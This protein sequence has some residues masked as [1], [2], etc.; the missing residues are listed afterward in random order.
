[1]RNYRVVLHNKYSGPCRSLTGR[2]DFIVDNNPT[3]FCCCLRHA[4]AMLDFYA[5][6]LADD[7]QVVTDRKGLLWKVDSPDALDRWCFEFDDLAA[8]ARLS[9]LNVYRATDEIYVLAHS[10]PRMP[11]PISNA[12]S[13]P[14]PKNSPAA[15]SRS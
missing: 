14:S 15:K 1:M 5:S 10:R 6:K 4:A 12:S 13:R 11:T 8:L 7:G 3:S 2:F 9:G